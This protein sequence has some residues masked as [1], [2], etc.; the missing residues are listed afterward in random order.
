MGA[1]GRVVSKQGRKENRFGCLLEMFLMLSTGGAAS[2]TLWC[3]WLL[4]GLRLDSRGDAVCANPVTQDFCPLVPAST[5]GCTLSTLN[6][7]SFFTYKSEKE[8]RAL[9]RTGELTFGEKPN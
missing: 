2:F 6:A 4:L 3:V 7:W 1:Q 8:A 5:E 9:F